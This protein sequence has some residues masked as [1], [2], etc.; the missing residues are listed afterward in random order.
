MSSFVQRIDGK[1]TNVQ[2]SRTI[3]ETFRP[4]KTKSIT[5]KTA[6]PDYSKIV[7]GHHELFE[8]LHFRTVFYRVNRVN[9]CGNIASVTL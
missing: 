4:P 6:S 8:N 3:F 7:D 5:G 2:L 1:C 9:D